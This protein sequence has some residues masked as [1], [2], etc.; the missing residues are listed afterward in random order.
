MSLAIDRFEISIS[1]MLM[2][3]PLPWIDGGHIT[4]VHCMSVAIGLKARLLLP[5]SISISMY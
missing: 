2:F 4:L 3:I 5:S 1:A